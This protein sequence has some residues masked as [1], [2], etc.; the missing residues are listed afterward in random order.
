MTEQILQDQRL[1][2][3]NLL[4]AVQRCVFFLEGIDRKIAW[5]L[6]E[7]FLVSNKKDRDLFESLAAYEKWGVIDSVETWQICRT[8]RNLAA[9]DYDTDYGDIAKHFNMLH[10]LKPRLYQV[11]VNF[12][13]HCEHR[14][15]SSRFQLNS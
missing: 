6:A 10:E 1:H 12:L 2:L 3:A 4:E 9:H 7:A 5:P 14:C 11:A 15:R 13:R 8:T